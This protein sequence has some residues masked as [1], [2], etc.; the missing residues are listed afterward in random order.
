MVG[1]IPFR[2]MPR[3]KRAAEGQQVIKMDDTALR[4]MQ[5]QVDMPGVKQLRE[6]VQQAGAIAPAKPLRPELGRLEG[7]GSCDAD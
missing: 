6:A 5:E 1:S 3:S 4:L 2:W 7:D